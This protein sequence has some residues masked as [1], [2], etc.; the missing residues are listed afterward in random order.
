MITT[1]SKN[2]LHPQAIFLREVGSKV[3]KKAADPLGK[4]YLI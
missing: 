2:N 1:F 3:I 4:V